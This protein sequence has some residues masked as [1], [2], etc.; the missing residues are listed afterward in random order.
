MP[1]GYQNIDGGNE[2]TSKHS[3]IHIKPMTYQELN[4]RPVHVES[5]PLVRSSGS[6]HE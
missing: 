3:G 1:H 5:S 6:V 2:P 4:Q